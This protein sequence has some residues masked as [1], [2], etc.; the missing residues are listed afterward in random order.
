MG[1]IKCFLQI[2]LLTAHPRRRS[3]A[4]LQSGQ[5][6]GFRIF[7]ITLFQEEWPQTHPFSSI[8]PVFLGSRGVGVFSLLVPLKLSPS[9]HP[10]SGFGWRLW[11][12]QESRQKE[13]PL[14]ATHSAAAFFCKTLRF[15]L[16][17]E[18]ITIS[19]L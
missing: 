7:R 9:Q 15:L 12:V 17:I 5:G 2:I 13:S 10:T 19:N 3:C 11:P 14:L 4:A 1:L 16:L 8:L 18:D 6:L